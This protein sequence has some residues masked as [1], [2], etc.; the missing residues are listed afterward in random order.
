M[1]DTFPGGEFADRLV[2]DQ[3]SSMFHG[4]GLRRGGAELR[5]IGTAIELQ[6]YGEKCHDANCSCVAGFHRLDGLL[7][8]WRCYAKSVH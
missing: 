7:A 3:L 2:A 8:Q 1:G 6:D 4:C 5:N